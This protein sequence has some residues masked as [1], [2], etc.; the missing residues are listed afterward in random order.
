MA[1]TFVTLTNPG[2]S[3]LFTRD[4]SYST[5]VA[6]VD[7]STSANVF[8]PDATNP[9]QEGEWL[10][11][12]ASTGKLKRA[13]ADIA[14]DLATPAALA[15][16]T[17]S[18]GTEAVSTSACF[19]NFQE[20]GRYDAQVTQKAH[21][22]LGPAPMQFRS[23]MLVCGTG[24]AGDKVFVIGCV[25]SSGRNVS[26]LASATAVAAA[27]GTPA[28]ADWYA[29]VITRVHGANDAEILFQPGWL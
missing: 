5:P 26:A 17:S 19:M 14:Y 16:N 6:N 28:T 12:D 29:G 25:V 3:A 11:T 27:G 24:D 18:G 1:G 23:K 21:C 13:C 8:D 10:T 2:Y 15:V 22:I 20:R 9:L 4:Y 7:G